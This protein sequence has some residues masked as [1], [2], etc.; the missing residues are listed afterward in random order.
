MFERET[1][2]IDL[3]GIDELLNVA[4]KLMLERLDYRLAKKKV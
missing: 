2:E 1:K 4:D 3:E